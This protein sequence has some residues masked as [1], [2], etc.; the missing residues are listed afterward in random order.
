[1]NAEDQKRLEEMQAEARTVPLSEKERWL[2][3]HL[4]VAEATCQS[5]LDQSSRWEAQALEAGVRIAELEARVRELREV[6]EYIQDHTYDFEI[7]KRITAALAEPQKGVLTGVLVEEK[8]DPWPT[9]TSWP[10]E[11]KKHG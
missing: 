8:E 11:G 6:L 10:Q 2:I 3:A 4:E 1:M 5:L 9:V 7:T